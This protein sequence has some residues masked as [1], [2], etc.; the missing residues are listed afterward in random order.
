[1]NFEGKDI[2]FEEAFHILDNISKDLDSDENDLEK[3]FELYKRGIELCKICE[4]ELKRLELQIEY[5][6]L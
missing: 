4:E 6:D 5:F 1:M 3:S 2:Y